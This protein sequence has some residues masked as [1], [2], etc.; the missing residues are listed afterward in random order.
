[1]GLSER[2]RWWT[3]SLVVLVG[4]E[5]ARWT[6]TDWW[7]MKEGKEERSRRG[8]RGRVG[9]KRRTRSVLAVEG[10]KEGRKDFFFLL[11]LFAL[12]SRV[13]SYIDLHDSERNK[14]P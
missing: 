5:R 7:Y 1:M 11:L 13:K 3:L 8:G 9:E 2:A 4:F 10:R 12:A 6:E 14:V